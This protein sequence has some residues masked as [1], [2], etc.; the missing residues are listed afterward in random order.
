MVPCLS[1]LTA[2]KASHPEPTAL[3]TGVWYPSARCSR[4]WLDSRRQR[5]RTTRAASMLRKTS[6]FRHASRNL[7]MKLSAYPFSHGCPGAMDHRARRLGSSGKPG[8][9]RLCDELGAVVAPQV[10]RCSP[11]HQQPRQR[12]D[13]LL[14]PQLPLD[15]DGQ[16]LAS[17]LIQHDEDLQDLTGLRAVEQKSYVQTWLGCSAR[18]GRPTPGPCRRRRGRLRGRITPRSSR[19]ARPVWH[20]PAAPGAATVP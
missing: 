18:G 1:T 16:T 2:G 13:D 10:L 4:R 14:G 12:P 20:A 8:V 17:G 3:S 19:C 9:P 6:S 11:P 7:P 5:S 15:P